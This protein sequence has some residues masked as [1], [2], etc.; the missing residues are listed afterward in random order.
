MLQYL[1]LR[2]TNSC[3]IGKK[4][5]AVSAYV[6]IITTSSLLQ[7][8][9]NDGTTMFLSFFQ[10]NKKKQFIE[11]FFL[12]V[13]T[14]VIQ[15]RSSSRCIDLCRSYDVSIFFCLPYMGASGNTVEH[16]AFRGIIQNF[17]TLVICSGAYF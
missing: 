6:Q 1:V 10:K 7:L 5:V 17:F 12:L 15:N 2:Q 3:R 14:I 11:H 9:A 8:Y 4:T 13:I 16:A